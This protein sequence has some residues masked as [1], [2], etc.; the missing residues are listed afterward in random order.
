MTAKTDAQ[1]WLKNTEKKHLL[2]LGLD[3]VGHIRSLITQIEGLER[4]IKN[5][6]IVESDSSNS[7]YFV[8][9]FHPQLQR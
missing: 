1:E 7:L 3:A 4:E 8:L 6:I 2:S 5:K 9:A